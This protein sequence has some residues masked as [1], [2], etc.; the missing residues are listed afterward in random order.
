MNVYEDCSVSPGI[1][2]LVTKIKSDPHPPLLEILAFM[3]YFL[4]AS[5]SAAVFLYG[6]VIVQLLSH[7]PRTALNIYEICMV[8]TKYHTKSI[9]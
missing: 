9:K 1:I 4:S 2:H 5:V 8:N 7:L 6:L 3:F